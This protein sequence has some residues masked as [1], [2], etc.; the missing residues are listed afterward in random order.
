MKTLHEN[1]ASS[2]PARLH[3]TATSKRSSPASSNAREFRNM[4]PNQPWRHV[5]AP[6]PPDEPKEELRISPRVQATYV[7]ATSFSSGGEGYVCDVDI[8][9]TA[10]T[11]RPAE[12]KNLKVGAARHWGLDSDRCR[13]TQRPA[14]RGIFFTAANEKADRFPARMLRGSGRGELCLVEEPKTKA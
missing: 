13:H 8:R 14:D 2:H 9:I 10:P 3:A 6:V 5:C 12:S 4:E 11:A 1:F 7:R